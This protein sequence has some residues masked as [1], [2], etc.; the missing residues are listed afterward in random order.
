VYVAVLV[1][2]KNVRLVKSNHD[3]RTMV[4]PLFAANHERGRGNYVP[5]FCF[6]LVLLNCF[7]NYILVN[8]H[9]VIGTVAV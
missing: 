8:V 5:I 9:R 1:E 7:V 2:N 3:H 6:V 4:Y